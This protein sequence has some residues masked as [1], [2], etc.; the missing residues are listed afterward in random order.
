MNH[1]VLGVQ[2]VFY[3]FPFTALSVFIYALSFICNCNSVSS[4]QASNFCWVIC[5]F[6][7]LQKGIKFFLP[8]DQFSL[9]LFLPTEQSLPK[10]SSRNFAKLPLFRHFLCFFFANFSFV[11][12]MKLPNQSN[13]FSFFSKNPPLFF[14]NV[15][16]SETVVLAASFPLDF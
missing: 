5:F 9:M 10:T 12:A 14:H 2:P 16:N 4:I 3:E 6:D 13:C 7:F 11:Y 1:Y 8:Q 15:N